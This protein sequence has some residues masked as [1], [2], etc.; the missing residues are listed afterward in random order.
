MTDGNFVIWGSSGHGLVLRDMV[1][2]K[3]V[4]LIDNDPRA[5]A[6]IPGLSVHHGEEGLRSFLADQPEEKL[7][8]L[9]AI[10]GARGEDRRMILALLR[11]YGL[12]TPVLCHKQSSVA[13]SATI[14]R[15]S[16]ILAQSTV[17]S[18]AELGEGV[19]VNHGAIVDHEC[20][21]SDGVHIAPGAT[22][23]GCVRI[24]RDAFVGAGATVLPRL[25]IGAGAIIGAGATVTS[26]VPAGTTV[27]GTPA[28]PSL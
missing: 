7:S 21:L 2:N 28:R 22:L 12:E 8:G 16:Q 19:I 10:G 20:H 18:A 4:A 6:I 26:D 5:T 14:G 23:C 24:E 11:R 9:V 27:V 1:E 15:G 13:A 3:V 25:H 17:A